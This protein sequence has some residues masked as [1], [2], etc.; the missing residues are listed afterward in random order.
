MDNDTHIKWDGYDTKVTLSDPISLGCYSPVR[1]ALTLKI[2]LS[3]ANPKAVEEKNLFGL[4]AIQL[5]KKQ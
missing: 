1:G 5:M 3:G 2:S 4:D